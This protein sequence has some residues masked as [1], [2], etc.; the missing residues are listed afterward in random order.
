M[1]DLSDCSIDTEG[2]LAIVKALKNHTTLRALNINGNAINNAVAKEVANVL[3]ANPPL[4]S[5][6]LQGGWI[7]DD[8]LIAITHSL[9]TN[10]HLISLDVRGNYYGSKAVKAAA[11]ALEK[12]VTLRSLYLGGN[13]EEDAVLALIRALASNV[14]LSE[15]LENFE[16]SW[17]TVYSSWDETRWD[18]EITCAQGTWSYLINGTMIASADT[19]YEFFE[20][21]IKS[22]ILPHELSWLREISLSKSS[23][24]PKKISE[25][26]SIGKKIISSSPPQ[27]RGRERSSSSRFFCAII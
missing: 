14:K 2:T 19:F 9:I 1:L 23:T 5:L 15:K 13:F 27:P 11:V 16:L 17:S 8:G 18:S 12:N 20:Q 22:D 24:A 10:T 3:E 25:I 7:G 26:S 6:N 21:I 4:R